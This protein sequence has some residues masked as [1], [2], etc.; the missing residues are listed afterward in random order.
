MGEGFVDLMY[1]EDD[2]STVIVDYKTDD[3]PDAAIAVRAAYYRPQIKA[4]LRCGEA[5]GLSDTTGVLLFLHPT[6]RAR[7]H[8]FSG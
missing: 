6:A 1:R 3:I 2:G 5:A 7:A 8:A 4:Y